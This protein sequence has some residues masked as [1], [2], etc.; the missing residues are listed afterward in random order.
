VAVSFE[1]CSVLER[2]KKGG[3]AI[4]FSCRFGD[5]FVDFEVV[6]GSLCAKSDYL[7]VCD[8]HWDRRSARCLHWRFGLSLLLGHGKGKARVLRLCNLDYSG[9]DSHDGFLFVAASVLEGVVQEI[10]RVQ[11][12]I[13]DPDF[14]WTPC[15]SFFDSIVVL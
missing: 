8:V 13:V 4:Y 5:E 15:S 6:L 3:G 9:I 1:F 14:D 10:D 11:D 12:S 7:G 2:D